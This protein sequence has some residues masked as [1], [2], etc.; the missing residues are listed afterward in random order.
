MDGL[1]ECRAYNIKTNT[2][3][4]GE[5]ASNVYRKDYRVV[6]SNFVMWLI[7]PT[8]IMTL[9][10]YGNNIAVKYLIR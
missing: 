5:I 6:K 9:L 3:A 8:A 7:M 2:I 1:Y 10:E 4:A